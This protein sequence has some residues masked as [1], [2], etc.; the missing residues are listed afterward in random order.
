MAPGPW[1]VLWLAWA[2]ACAFATR[3]AFAALARRWLRFGARLAAYG[4]WLVL[5]A[6]GYAAVEISGFAPYNSDGSV[7]QQVGAWVLA[8]SP[9]GLPLLVGAPA[10]L[11]F[12]AVVTLVRGPWAVARKGPDAQA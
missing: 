4:G 2:I 7:R 12:D 9:L 11:L 6:I 8:Y 10:V 5:L 3:V 1:T